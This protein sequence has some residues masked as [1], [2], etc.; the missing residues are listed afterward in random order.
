MDELSLLDMDDIAIQLKYKL[1][2]GYCIEVSGDNIGSAGV[3]IGLGGGGGV[4]VEVGS[5]GVNIGSAIVDIG[6][7][8]G[9]VK[10]GLSGGGVKNGPV[11]ADIGSASV[12][13]NMPAWVNENADAC[14][15]PI[16]DLESLQVPGILHVEYG[17]GSDIDLG[18][19][20]LR[21]LDESDGEEDNGGPQ[22][23]FIKTKYHEFNPSCDMQDPIF[24]V[25]SADLFRKAIRGYVVKH[26]RSM[27]RLMIE[28]ENA[29]KW[30]LDKEPIQWSRVFFKDTTLYDMLCNNMCEAFNKAILQAR[31]K[32]VITL[33]EMIMNYLMKILVRKRIEVE[34]WHNDIGPK[35]L[36]FVKRM[37][38]KN[39]RKEIGI[40]K[41]V[42][43]LQSDKVRVGGKTKLRKN[44][45]V[46]RCTK[47]RQ[48]GHNRGTYD[49]MTEMIGDVFNTVARTE[50]GTGI[51]SQ[52]N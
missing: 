36:K 11:G 16:R 45:V 25:G 6:L 42:R 31:D 23:K 27:E 50:V 13:G 8:G 20:D 34:K 17:S 24:R 18:S 2:V 41:K 40:P 19:D 32:P 37:K 39:F 22:R 29:Y 30:L 1:P 38:L 49:R 48:E 46:I 26:M 5:G 52:S 44:Y 35:V 9:G 4:C 28:S 43:N 3:D 47:C 21:N 51:G 14:V 7:G 10:I 33:M 12:V 15:D